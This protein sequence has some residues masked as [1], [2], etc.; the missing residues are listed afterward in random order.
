[1]TKSAEYRDKVFKLLPSLTYLDGFDAND[2]EAIDSEDEEGR[3]AI[4]SYS[5]AKMR[6][7]F[8][9]VLPE[10]LAELKMLNSNLL[11]GEGE[12]RFADQ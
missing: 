4:L 10:R 1:M 12:G 3:Y 8:I 11:K 7:L 9:G 6:L 2:V 5:I